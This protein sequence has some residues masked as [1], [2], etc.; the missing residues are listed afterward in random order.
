MQTFRPMINGT[1]QQVTFVRTYVNVHEG[2]RLHIGEQP[3]GAWSLVPNG[4]PI[5]ERDII[6]R[7][8]PAGPDRERAL[9]WFE[10]RLDPEGQAKPV[11]K[12]YFEPEDETYRFVDTQQ[13]VPLREHLIDAL[14]GPAL[15]AAMV[16][17]HHYYGA[18]ARAQREAA[19]QTPQGWAEQILAALR[20]EAHG[21]SVDALAEHFG[22]P[23]GVIGNILIPYVKTQQVTKMGRM[24]YYGHP[25]AD[26]P[27]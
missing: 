4:F 5:I 10:P 22:C 7:C 23:T 17:F 8:V 19:Q 16:W 14:K 20:A 9:A 11:R 27:A 2:A 24:Y 21:A 1:S 13:V 18:A 26:T 3:S 6:L 12:V 25:Q 15:D